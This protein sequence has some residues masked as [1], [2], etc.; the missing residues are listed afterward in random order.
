[1]KKID[2]VKMQEMIANHLRACTAWEIEEFAQSR[3]GET[4]GNDRLIHYINDGLEIGNYEGKKLFVE[5][6][7]DCI[8]IFTLVPHE[9]YV[10]E[11]FVEGKEYT[12]AQFLTR[13]ALQLDREFRA[14]EGRA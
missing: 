4:T 13:I 1:M 7:G 8:T 3:C 12:Q 6:Y 5:C 2:T 10:I 14:L 11:T 9:G